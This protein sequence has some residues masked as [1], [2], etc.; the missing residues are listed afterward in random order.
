MAYTIEYLH[1]LND[2]AK[3]IGMTMTKENVTVI[4]IMMKEPTTLNSRRPLSSFNY[5]SK[6]HK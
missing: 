1:K 5:S 2:Y 6:Y 3:S 4:D